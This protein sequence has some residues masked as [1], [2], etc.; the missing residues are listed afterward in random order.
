MCVC[1]CVCLCVCVCRSFVY[2]IKMKNLTL[3][4]LRTIAEMKN[5]KGYERMSKERLISSV[6]ESKRVK[7]KNFNDARIEKIKIDFNKLSDFLSQKRKRLEK[8][9]IE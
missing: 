9:F 3:E 1:V 7:E 2:I 8:I 5:I 6:N 4:E